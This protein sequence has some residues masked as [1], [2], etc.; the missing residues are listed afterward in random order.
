MKT[1]S[2][3]TS[4]TTSK[5]TNK[6]PVTVEGGDVLVEIFQ[7]DAAVAFGEHIDS[8]GEQHPGPFWRQ[9]VSHAWNT[10]T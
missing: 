10:C 8:Q 2:N 3:I 7:G 4:N 6:E 9:G 5:L 1:P